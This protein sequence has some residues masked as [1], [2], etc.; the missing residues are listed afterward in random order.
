MNKSHLKNIA[1]VLLAGVAFF[2]VYKY[3][4]AMRE[5]YGLLDTIEQ[6]KRQ[7]SNLEEKQQ[8]LLQTLEKEKEVQ[9]KITQKNLKLED[10]LMAGRKRL[11]KLFRQ[12]YGIQKE[13]DDLN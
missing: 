1:I 6:L 11:D 3:T 10:T 8:N 9:S 5:K 13:L 12:A 2:S 4:L 7:V